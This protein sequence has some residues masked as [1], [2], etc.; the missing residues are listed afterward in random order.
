M[1]RSG[2]NAPLVS[3]LN[4]CF[5]PFFD[6]EGGELHGDPGNV[7][8]FRDGARAPAQAFVEW[9]MPIPMPNVLVSE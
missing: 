5:V 8:S 3:A 4:D 9:A 7:V 2:S 1:V 6:D